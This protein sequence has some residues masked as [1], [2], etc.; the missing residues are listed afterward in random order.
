MWGGLGP[1]SSKDHE[2]PRS[3]SMDA[4]SEGKEL[5]VNTSEGTSKIE[6]T[7]T[8]DLAVGLLDFEQLEVG[9]LTSLM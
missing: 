6:R 7:K 4:W 3:F 9:K 5:I 1:K 2:L 8:L